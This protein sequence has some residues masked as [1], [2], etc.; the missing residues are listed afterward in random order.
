MIIDL[1]G[2]TAIITGASMGLGKAM[3]ERFVK[4]GANVLIAA[5]GAD[6]VE[7]AVAE[8]RPHGPERIAGMACD[9]TDPA[10]REALVAEARARFG[11]IDIL[12]NNAG[13][14]FRRDFEDLSR[15]DMIADLDLK[16]F[17]AAALTQ[18]VLPDM[19]QRRRG[20]IINV[21]AIGGK[22][23][24]AGSAPTSLSRAAGIAMT[25]A[26]SREL[27]Q[28][29]ILVNTLL[30]GKIKSGQWERRYAA[31]DRSR[32]YEEF[33]GPQAKQIPLGRMGEA[34]EFANVACFL[35]SDAASYVTGVAINVDGGM[36]PVP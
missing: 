11:G 12:V 21:T 19:K 1:A 26:L 36:C 32:T 17:A 4:S 9:V 2:R 28:H 5:R 31:S 24:D 20:R 6:G 35:A 3:A 8:I 33:L 25:K 18:L 15:D 14:S 30:V 16:L 13:S 34:E 27:G 29:N 23:P 7:A 10:A 22:T